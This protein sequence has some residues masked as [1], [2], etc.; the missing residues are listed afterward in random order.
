MKQKLHDMGFS[1]HDTKKILD[2][3]FGYQIGSEGLVDAT[4]E[5]DFDE[6]LLGLTESWNDTHF[7][8]GDQ[9]HLRF[10]EEKAVSFKKGVIR[11]V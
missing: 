6:K 4:S 1:T 10:K 8:L 9:F 7:E 2:D 5:D 3:I 11:P